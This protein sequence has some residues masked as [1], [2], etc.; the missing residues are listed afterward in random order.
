MTASAD[1]GSGPRTVYITTGMVEALLELASVN[2]PDPVSTG[3]STVP[4]GEL[5]GDR[6]ESFDPAQPVFAEYLLPDPGNSLTHVFGVELSTPNRSTQ[7]RFV[8]HPDGVLDVT[9]RDDLGAVVL[10]AVPPWEPDETSLRAFDRSGDRLTLKVLDAE[11]P[12][13]PFED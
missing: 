12:E 8:S 6:V 13:R 2:D 9:L 1:P 10:V 7:G 11:P 4:A 5:D 3:I